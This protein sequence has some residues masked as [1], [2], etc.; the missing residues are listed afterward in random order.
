LTNGFDLAF[1]VGAGFALAGAII[2]GLRLRNPAPTGA[3]AEVLPETLAE[4]EE[5]EALAV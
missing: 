2:A 4:I 5:S 3:R 1:A